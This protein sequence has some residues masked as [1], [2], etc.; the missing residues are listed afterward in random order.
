MQTITVSQILDRLHQLSIE[1]LAV[2]YDFVSYLAERDALIQSQEPFS[3]S[4]D[5]LWASEAILRQDW[6]RPE[7]DIAWANL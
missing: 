4:Q 1:K 2:V 7:E 3:S 5:V 6:E